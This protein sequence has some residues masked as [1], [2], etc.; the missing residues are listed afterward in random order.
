MS[1]LFE[2]LDK[3]KKKKA[4]WIHY[5][6]F[7]QFIWSQIFNHMLIERARFFNIILHEKMD[8]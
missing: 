1:F 2:L 5:I 6:R 8:Q 4:S 3:K 7:S